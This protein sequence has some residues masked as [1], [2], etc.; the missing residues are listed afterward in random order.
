[1]AQTRGGTKTR[2]SLRY[3]IKK[4]VP[5]SI[6]SAVKTG[7]SRIHAESLEE[8]GSRGRKARRTMGQ[9]C[10]ITNDISK[11]AIQETEKLIFKCRH[12]LLEKGEMPEG[13]KKK[14][15]AKETEKNSSRLLIKTHRVIVTVSRFTRLSN[16][17]KEGWKGE[18]AILEKRGG[19]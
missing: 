10:T 5:S 19:T 18:V 9:N 15:K 14:K 4:F 3:K 6:M 16:K 1:L 2:D 7:R 13:Q 12:N 8:R 17:I 11:S